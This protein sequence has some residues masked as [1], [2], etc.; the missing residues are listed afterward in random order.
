LG[1]WMSTDRGFSRL[2]GGGPSDL[3]LRKPWPRG[4]PGEST[5][6]RSKL[7]GSH[8]QRPWFHGIMTRNL[9]AVLRQTKWVIDG[10][11]GAPRSSTRSRLKKLGIPRSPHEPSERPR[12]FVTPGPHLLGSHSPAPARSR[13]K[14]FIR[15]DHPQNRFPEHT[16]G[17]GRANPAGRVRRGG[18]SFAG[19]PAMLRSARGDVDTMRL[20]TRVLG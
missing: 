16:L 9:L 3:T 17:T 19:E 2:L 18:R 6:D 4:T 20:V 11:C 10:R 13:L 15:R 12:E 7:F 8:G 1:A 5:P 14:S